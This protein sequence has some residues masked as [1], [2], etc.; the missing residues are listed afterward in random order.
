MSASIQQDKQLGER[1]RKK[2]L[3]KNSKRLYV[4]KEHLTSTQG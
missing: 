1:F 3:H 2:I 4:Q